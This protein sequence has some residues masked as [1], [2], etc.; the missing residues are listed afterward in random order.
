MF[1]KKLTYQAN[2]SIVELDQFLSEFLRIFNSPIDE[3]TVEDREEL[4]NDVCLKNKGRFFEE[5]LTAYERCIKRV[6]KMDQTETMTQ[7]S[8]KRLRLLSGHISYICA[9]ETDNNEE[10]SAAALSYKSVIDEFRGYSRLTSSAQS[11][12]IR[13]Y[14][15]TLR[16][17]KYAEAFAKL[18]L[19]ERTN[20]LEETN[21]KYIQLASERAAEQEMIPESPSKMRNQCI[22]AYRYLVDII[23]FA[24]Q[25]NKFFH[26]DEMA[27]Q[28]AGITQNAQELINRRRNVSET[29]E[30]TENQENTVTGQP[31]GSTDK[32]S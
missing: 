18:D 22:K 25:N 20:E 4:L 9:C 2:L 11:T 31:E 28:L 26:Y 32:V 6:R 3:P 10:V 14:I 27:I 16:S 17:E 7:T 5:A 12:H 15:L 24:L 23:N 30:D 29:E 21:E 1:L 8:K 13:R 19:E